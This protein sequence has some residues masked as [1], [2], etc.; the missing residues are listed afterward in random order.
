M[1]TYRL[2]LLAWRYEYIL[3]NEQ[4]TFVLAIYEYSQTD[5]PPDDHGSLL[6]RWPYRYMRACR[7][8]FASWVIL[9]WMFWR[10]VRHVVDSTAPAKV[11]AT[12]ALRM[13]T[14]P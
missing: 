3:P 1:G 8:A 4:E 13:C 12:S 5:R 9:I 7:G 11:P 2:A 14:S 6:R 10:G